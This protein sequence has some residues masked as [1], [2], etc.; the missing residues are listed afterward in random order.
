MVGTEFYELFQQAA[1]KDYSA[2]LDSTRA[3]RLIQR[4]LIRMVEKIYSSD[5]S[6][7]ESDELYS[8]IVKNE[9]HL[10]TG[11]VFAT[12]NF[13]FP[14]MHLLRLAC[15]YR[16]QITFSFASGVFTSAGHT[17]R[18][19]DV[20]TLSGAT[21]TNQ[22]G[23]Y[24]V[25]KVRPGKFYIPLTYED[26]SLHLIRTFEATYK[27]SDRK[28]SSLHSA[29]VFSPK[30]EQS[31]NDTFTVPNALILDPAP[32]KIKFDYVMKPDLTIDVENDA[33]DLLLYYNEKFIYRLI[34]ECVLTFAEETRD[35]Q[36]RQIMAQTIVDNP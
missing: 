8:M 7:K 17:L 4:S 3:N 35:P 11:G 12:D 15:I 34:D 27:R 16:D 26:G 30:Y 13:D 25:T 10:V 6:Q 2:Y 20:L 23:N 5:D 19:G 14:Y 9:E 24:T 36:N 29:T 21:D 28:F 22:N 1:D 33:T 31:F 18:K 32:Y